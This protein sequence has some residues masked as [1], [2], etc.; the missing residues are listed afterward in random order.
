MEQKKKLYNKY[1]D[2]LKNF[3]IILQDTKQY[4]FKHGYHLFYLFLIKNLKIKTSEINF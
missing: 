3:G 2:E 4:K 1:F